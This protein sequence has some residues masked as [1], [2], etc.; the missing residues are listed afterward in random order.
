MTRTAGSNGPRTREAIMSAGL[1]LI[2][3][4]G[5]EAVTIRQLAAAVNLTQ[6]A[7]Y[8]HLENKQQLLYELV[9]EHMTD[10]LAELANAMSGL[11]EPRERLLRFIAF[12][13]EYHATRRREIYIGNSELRSLTPP[14]KAEILGLRTR[15]EDAFIAILQA[16]HDAGLVRVSN[17][18]IT[19]YAIL[20]MLTG[21]SAWYNPSKPLE[22]EALARIHTDLVLFGLR[23]SAKRDRA[24]SSSL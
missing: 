5:Y 9:R 16:A 20:A 19:A 10:L 13:I 2:Y 24:E 22:L 3:E 23:G 12:H 1:E 17:A 18:K 11:T 14:N 21:I 8:N 15:Y 4:H 6:G 7:I